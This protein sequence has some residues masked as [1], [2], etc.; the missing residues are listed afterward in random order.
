MTLRKTTENYKNHN[1]E[2]IRAE[3]LILSIY[4]YKTD[5]QD[6]GIQPNRIIMPMDYYRKIKIYHAGLGEIQGKFGDYITEDEIFGL[7]VYIDQVS[8]IHVE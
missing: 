3:E 7:P 1:D 8:E 2:N 5:L 4:K 6:K